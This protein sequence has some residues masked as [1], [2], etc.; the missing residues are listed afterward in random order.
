MSVRDFSNRDRTGP[1]PTIEN[2]TAL[3]YSF[4]RLRAATDS[5]QASRTVALATM[6]SA[7]T[8]RQMACASD[9]YTPDITISA[10]VAIAFKGLHAQNR[11]RSIHLRS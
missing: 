10:A 2:V 11:L 3:V 8:S 4:N 7:T 9:K 6:A 5:R 1:A